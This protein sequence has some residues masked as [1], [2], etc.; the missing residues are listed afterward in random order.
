VIFYAGTI[1]YFLISRFCYWFAAVRFERPNGRL[2]LYTKYAGKASQEAPNS[3][4]TCLKLLWQSRILAS[5]LIS[6][7][8]GG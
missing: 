2:S 8:L 1:Y 4:I 5:I 3:P 7:L 6:R